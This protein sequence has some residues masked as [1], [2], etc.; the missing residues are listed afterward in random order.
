MHFIVPL[1]LFFHF[2][3]TKAQTRVSPPPA[4]IEFSELGKINKKRV[5]EIRIKDKY[6]LDKLDAIEKTIRKNTGL[7]RDEIKRYKAIASNLDS[8]ELEDF[9]Q[10]LEESVV[11]KNLK[12]VEKVD[13]GKKQREK[14]KNHRENLDEYKEQ[15]TGYKNNLSAVST[16]HQKNKQQ[17]LSVYAQLGKAEL[18]ALKQEGKSLLNDTLS[19]Y[20]NG[21]Q[22]PNL[23][24]TYTFSL[25]SMAK[26]SALKTSVHNE[27]E[28]YLEKYAK[29]KF[30]EED[31]LFLD[32]YE[33][34]QTIVKEYVPKVEKFNYKKPEIPDKKLAE[35]MVEKEKK[36]KRES[37]EKLIVDNQ[38]ES[39]KNQ[40]W[41]NR[42]VIGGY[43]EYNPNI[44]SVELTPTLAYGVNKR[45]S[46][47][48]G[49]GTMIGL[50]KE[51]EIDKFNLYRVF[52]TY[53]LIRSFFLHLESE[54]IEQRRKE[55]A[56]L[57]ARSTYIGLGRT[58][59]Y[60]Q[61]STNMLFLYNFSAPTVLD[62]QR[63]SVRF[64][65]NFNP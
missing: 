1:L 37:L 36:R 14:I 46:M 8:L 35:A 63:F 19:S 18:E 64:A 20:T 41:I 52:G 17:K 42:W 12:L 32:A 26:D 10:G 3:G 43:V 55:E 60:R 53:V 13:Q 24:S 51:N 11:S 22:I 7:D 25:D 16:N 59:R 28:A 5:M 62:A 30:G 47:G 2:L 23:D 33:E 34:P 39:L 21:Y 58:F 57:K 45:F 54:W 50:D 29:E 27:M 15:Y 6:K 56:L 31:L 48:V 61:L 44:H 49:Y 4:K 40:K 38:D 9:Q 65:L